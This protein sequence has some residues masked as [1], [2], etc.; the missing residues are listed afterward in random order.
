[1]EE[2]EAIP[3]LE[4]E[5]AGNWKDL[6]KMRWSTESAECLQW[7]LSLLQGRLIDT[8]EVATSKWVARVDEA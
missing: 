5:V 8:K 6:R 7:E 1:M 3:S 2:G 4:G